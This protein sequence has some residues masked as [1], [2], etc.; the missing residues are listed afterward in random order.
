MCEKTNNN[1]VN[2]GKTND[3]CEC[4][5]AINKI[6]WFDH[7]WFWGI[8]TVASIIIF[9]FLF[10]LSKG[11][12]WSFDTGRPLKLWSK[13]YIYLSLVFCVAVVIVF[14]SQIVFILYKYKRNNT[15]RDIKNF[16]CAI[17]FYVIRSGVSIGGTLRN[18]IIKLGD[19]NARTYDSV[20]DLINDIIYKCPKKNTKFAK[21]YD[22]EINHPGFRQ[23][24]NWLFCRPKGGINNIQSHNVFLLFLRYFAALTII[25]CI[26]YTV[27]W[28]VND[29]VPVY[30]TEEN[31]QSE[32]AK[33][34][35]AKGEN[36]KDDPS[37]MI[38]YL[39]MGNIH[40]ENE[41]VKNYHWCWYFTIF[42]SIMVVGA[43]FMA[44]IT[45][46][47]VDE[48]PALIFAPKIFYDPD[49]DKRAFTVLCQS[50]DYASLTDITY[51]FG[52]SLI[53]NDKEKR[54]AFFG[55]DSD[56]NMCLFLAAL[57][58]N[59]L[60]IDPMITIH[61][62]TLPLKKKKPSD[63][64]DIS[65]DEPCDYYYDDLKEK[66]ILTEVHKRKYIQ[67]Y[68]TLRIRTNE[69]KEEFL[70]SD[71]D[72]KS[73]KL[74][75]IDKLI[76]VIIHARSVTTGTEFI[77]QKDYTMSDVV[78][79]CANVKDF[80]DWYD[81][82]L[83]DMY[84]GN[85]DSIILEVG[86]A[87]YKQYVEGKKK[88]KKDE[89]ETKNIDKYPCQHCDF[90]KS[91]N[92]PLKKK[93]RI[94]SCTYENIK[95]ILALQKAVLKEN[96]KK[97][98]KNQLL[99]TK[100]NEFEDCLKNG[101]IFGAFCE[102]KLI[103]CIAMS[104]G[105]KDKRF[106]CLSEI[107]ENSGH[108]KIAYIELVIVDK[109]F[110]GRGLQKELLRTLEEYIRKNSE[111]GFMGAMASPDNKHSLIGFNASG[112]EI[113]LKNG[114]SSAFHVQ[115]DSSDDRKFSIVLDT[116]PKDSEILVIQAGSEEKYDR[117][118]LFKNINRDNGNQS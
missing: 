21:W 61:M 31:A 114:G 66:N 51:F 94:E 118:L 49:P 64:N 44:A 108:K 29:T 9:D 80:R 88:E 65:R 98:K 41:V 109:D 57:S 67:L 103:A 12:E 107:S 111:Y 55:T 5:R 70:F 24:Y 93:I 6:N 62:E 69:N 63:K 79:G 3:E 86:T 47:F 35:N 91:D 50:Q 22:D 82:D 4:D 74:P 115:E 39:I 18:L 71:S 15:R 76:R 75:D 7:I 48:K 13:G 95:A 112:F 28:S 89:K 54:E 116:A 110:R 106:E 20:N 97:G 45:K 96:K 27:F 10:I 83:I 85:F 14:Y 8:I 26:S 1:N 73:G 2:L 16:A 90:N 60:S 46:K 92:C 59:A 40:D 113:A 117:Y 19:K 38:A 43:L 100:R 32:N 25:F 37:Y 11:F 105:S 84:N 81:S 78:C 53:F 102:G 23:M 68:P 30:P 58:Q 72:D 42:M 104:T 99:I 36:P 34:E 56:K 87:A 77:W 101:Q 33:G 17:G 52:I